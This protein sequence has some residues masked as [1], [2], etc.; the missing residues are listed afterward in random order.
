MASVYGDD[1]STTLYKRD[2]LGRIV[3]WRISTDGIKDKVSFGSFERLS[4]VG[5]V[6][7]STSTKTSYNSQIKRKIDRGYKTAEMY[8]ITDDMY[9]SAN[10]LH[11]LL[12]NV[13]PKFATDAN[14]V[15]KPMKCQKW[16]R[17]IF[18]YSNG[19]MADPKING[20]RCTIKYEAVDNGLFGISHEVVI[21]SKE[22]LR[23]NVKHIEEAFAKYVFVKNEYKD[24]AFDGELYIKDQ[25]NTSIGGAARN[26]KNPLHKHLQFVNFDLS[27]PDMSNVDR[28]VLRRNILMNAELYAINQSDTTSIFIQNAIE[29][30]SDTI[31]ASIVSLSSNLFIK[32]DDDVEAYRD[33]CIGAGYE[34]CVVRVKTAEYQ[35]G[36]RPQTMMKA[37]KCEETECL[38]IDI[39]ID[40]ITKEIDGKSITYEYAKFKCRN[41]LNDEIFEIKPTS[42]YNGITDETMTSDYIL[43]HRNQ[44][45]GKMLAIKF[46]ER[47]D[48]KIPFNANAY[49][50]RDYESND[51]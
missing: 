37:K 33:K 18:D 47:T 16:K 12:D 5:Q 1:K 26:P 28:Y 34:G 48:K 22:G 51:D 14:N 46:Y 6:I 40:K 11:D 39:L 13:I 36:S 24:I 4:D 44:F 30:H 43:S 21:R 3:Y 10:Q 41:D 19:A 9:E 35:F 49:G 2:A 17:G 29:S 15:D 38:C 50:V 31:K 7:I 23:Y 8:G 45:I 42:V 32:N 25:K 27:I 20:V